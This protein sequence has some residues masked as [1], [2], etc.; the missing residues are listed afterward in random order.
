AVARH[1]VSQGDEARATVDNGG[2][3][4]QRMSCKRTLTRELPLW[5]LRSGDSHP[6]QRRLGGTDRDVLLHLTRPLSSFAGADAGRDEQNVAPPSH[7]RCFGSGRRGGLP[8]MSQSSSTS[9][10]KSSG[11]PGTGGLALRRRS[12]YGHRF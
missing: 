5:R 2:S 4:I 11:V 6:C 7:F 9:S 1:V 3:D 10:T 8:Q 12:P